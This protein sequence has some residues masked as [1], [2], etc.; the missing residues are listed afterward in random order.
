M[1]NDIFSFSDLAKLNKRKLATINFKDTGKHN[2][3]DKLVFDANSK[4]I[5]QFPP[6]FLSIYWLRYKFKINV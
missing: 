5:L 4:I 3:L 1:V 6:V 2:M